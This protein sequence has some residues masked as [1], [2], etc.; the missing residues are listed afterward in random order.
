MG[1]Y[2]PL[3]AI[4]PQPPSVQR[5]RDVTRRGRERDRCVGDQT[6]WGDAA[7]AG[8]TDSGM[9]C[10]ARAGRSGRVG[11]WLFSLALG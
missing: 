3:L 11:V 4:E 6:L 7:S 10:G 5:K 9:D 1:F 2:G 8:R